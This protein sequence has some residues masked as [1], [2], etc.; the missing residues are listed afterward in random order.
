V[1]LKL[2]TSDFLGRGK[3]LGLTVFGSQTGTAGLR[4]KD[5]AYGAE[6]TYPNDFIE[7]GYRYRVQGENY[8]PALGFVSRRG[9]RFSELRT[10]FRPRPKFWA[11]RQMNYQ[12]NYT[13]FYNLA[14]RAVESRKIFTAPVNWRFHG[15]EHLEYNWQPT[16]ER[17]F[18]PFE[19]HKGILIPAGSYWFH[20]NRLEFN[21]AQNKPVMFDMTYWFGSFYTGSSHELRTAVS[22]RKNRH[23]TTSVEVQQYIV[24]LKEGDFDTRLALL[25]FDYSFTPFLA[26]SNFI[27]Y[28]T[29]SHNLGLQSRLRWIIKPGNELFLVVNHAWQQNTLDRFEALRTNARAKLNYNFRF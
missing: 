14:F 11:I 21:S 28:D 22:W 9:A 17:L 25:K 8:N 26:L 12:F 15:G 16:F 24:R 7:V 19:I 3:N 20:R 5:D 18:A 6:V 13:S 1:D 29:D 23:L 10:N 4:G 27:Q 2:F